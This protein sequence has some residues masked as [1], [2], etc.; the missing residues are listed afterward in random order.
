LSLEDNVHRCIPR[1]LPSCIVSRAPLLHHRQKTT[2]WPCLR[3]AFADQVLLS[4]RSLSGLTNPAGCRSGMEMDPTTGMETGGGARERWRSGNGG[5]T[6]PQT[7][8]VSSE[9]SSDGKSNGRR[10]FPE[11]AL[12]LVT[13]SIP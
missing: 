9:A 2:T 3:R 6:Q 8:R 10:N 11:F 7:R 4:N 13:S 5:R 1:T 12:L